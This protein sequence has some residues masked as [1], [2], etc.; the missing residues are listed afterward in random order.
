MA[1]NATPAPAVRWGVLGAAAIATSRT[2]PA[3]ASAPSASL[4]ALASR[5]LARA[6]EAAAPFGVSHVHGSYDALLA[7][8]DVDVVYIPLPNNLHFEW[9]VRAL[10][11]GKHVL[12]EKPLVLTSRE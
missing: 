4:V 8:L 3:F 6:R 7:D 12:C 9:C 11:A 5:D 2:M 10:E 1:S